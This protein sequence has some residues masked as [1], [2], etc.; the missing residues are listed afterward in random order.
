MVGLDNAG[1]T[2]V[3]YKLKASGWVARVGAVGWMSAA[4]AGGVQGDVSTGR[5][6]IPP[7][8]AA[9]SLPRCSWA[10]TCPPCPR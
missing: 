9:P 2:T 3:L 8:N 1:K 10:R 4:A 5:R 7:T 6:A